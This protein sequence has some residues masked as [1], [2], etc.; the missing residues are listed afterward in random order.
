MGT[1]GQFI[2]LLLVIGVVGTYFWPIA[3]TLAAAW[4]TYR[5]VLHALVGPRYPQDP[6]NDVVP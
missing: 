1:L 6:V 3:L 4:V 5:I 2:T